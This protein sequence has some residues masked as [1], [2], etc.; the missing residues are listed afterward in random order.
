MKYAAITAAARMRA[1]AAA[2]LGVVPYFLW[3]HSSKQVTNMAVVSATQNAQAKMM[4]PTP[5]APNEPP[6]AAVP[7]AAP[8][9]AAPHPTQAPPIDAM[10]EWESREMQST[11]HFIRWAGVAPDDFA[12]AVAVPLDEPSLVELAA[13]SLMIFAES[14]R[15]PR[16]GCTLS[17]GGSTKLLARSLAISGLTARFSRENCSAP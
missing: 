10:S 4:S 1:A 5:S 2:G 12:A 14:R 11:K 8:A 17:C 3:W 7:A 6:E 13:G 16:G 15:L 9:I